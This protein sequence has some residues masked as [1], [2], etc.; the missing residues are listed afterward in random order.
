MGKDLPDI[1]PI[2]TLWDIKRK[3]KLMERF[4][5]VSFHSENIKGLC[6]IFDIGIPRGVKALMGTKYCPISIS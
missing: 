5:Q 1:T 6:N 2:E 3:L 4:I